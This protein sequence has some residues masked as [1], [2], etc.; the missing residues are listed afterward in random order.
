MPYTLPVVKVRLKEDWQLHIGSERVASRFRTRSTAESNALRKLVFRTILDPV[1]VKFAGFDRS[2]RPMSMFMLLGLDQPD[3][4][5][6][7]AAFASISSFGADVVVPLGPPRSEYVSSFGWPLS[8]YFEPDHL[9]YDRSAFIRDE[10]ARALSLEFPFP[11][12]AR[13]KV[14][15]L[16]LACFEPV[17]TRQPKYTLV[18]ESAINST[19]TRFTYRH[20]ALANAR[21]S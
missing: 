4:S 10:M 21:R 16:H 12:P 9:N 18:S 5:T 8:P 3:R 2:S 1:A 14:H 11:H 19:T 15:Y 7:D 20:N 6:Q 17:I 13:F